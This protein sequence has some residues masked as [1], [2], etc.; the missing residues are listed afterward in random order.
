MQ[1]LLLKGFSGLLMIALLV[2]VVL[3]LVMALPS[4]FC[5]VFWN[6]IV[7]EGFRGPEINVTQA[8]LL[9]AAILALLNWRFKPQFTLQFKRVKDP[10]ELEQL[11]KL[12][13][14]ATQQANRQESNSSLTATVIEPKVNSLQ[15]T[16]TASN[17]KIHPL[18]SPEASSVTPSTPTGTLSVSH[19]LPVTPIT[20][21]PS[22]EQQSA[23]T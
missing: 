8:I 19:R 11:A 3:T 4:L 17:I 21:D 15:L 16:A 23:S 1:I 18:P 20:D 13:K 22:K 12:S 9:W 6:A 2:V 14:Q 5:L 10:T 7:F